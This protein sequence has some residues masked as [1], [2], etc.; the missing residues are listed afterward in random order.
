[1]SPATRH[2]RPLDS[3][4]A[5]REGVTLMAYDE[6]VFAKDAH[7]KE[8]DDAVRM[9]YTGRCQVA[10]MVVRLISGRGCENWSSHDA[11]AQHM[12]VGS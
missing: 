9:V 6:W 8:P 12:G 3:Y 10:N 11:L 2:P 1:M 7:D 5:T 4:A